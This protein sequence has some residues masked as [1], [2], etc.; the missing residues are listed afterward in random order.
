MIDFLYVSTLKG[1]LDELQYGCSDLNKMDIK[2]ITNVS[3][4]IDTKELKFLLNRKKKAFDDSPGIVTNKL[5]PQLPLP[6]DVI[7]TLV[8]IQNDGYLIYPMDGSTPKIPEGQVDFIISADEPLRV[9][10]FEKNTV[11]ER[12]ELRDRAIGAINYGHSSLAFKEDGVSI[13]TNPKLSMERRKS[14]STEP[15]LLAGTIFFPDHDNPVVGGGEMLYWTNDSGHFKPTL[16]EVFHNRIGFIKD[17]LPMEKFI[18]FDSSEKE[19]SRILK[20]RL[21][22]I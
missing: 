19:N 16:K 8:K 7:G 1:C 5:F 14:L 20:K 4:S 17:I 12:K 10:C 18:P 21:F 9:L 22:T 15:V 11:Y 6:K 13:A 3:K 2:K